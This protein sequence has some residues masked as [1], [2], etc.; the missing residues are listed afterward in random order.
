[1]LDVIFNNP[2]K[3]WWII[4]FSEAP[5][6]ATLLWVVTMLTPGPVLF[7]KTCKGFFQIDSNNL[8]AWKGR[9]VNNEKQINSD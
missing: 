8:C 9:I 7:S 3:N 1:M 4:F 2:A 6:S 5:H